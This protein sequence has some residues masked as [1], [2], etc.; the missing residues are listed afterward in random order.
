MSSHPLTLVITSHRFI[1]TRGRFFTSGYF[2]YQMTIYRQGRP[3]ITKEVR[4]KDFVSFRTEL[5]RLNESLPKLPKTGSRHLT[6]LGEAVKREQLLNLFLQRLVQIP[7]I[8]SSPLFRNFCT[9]CPK[10]EVLSRWTQPRLPTRSTP[11]RATF[12]STSKQVSADISRRESNTLIDLLNQSGATIQPSS[13]SSADIISPFGV[14]HQNFYCSICDKKCTSEFN[15]SQHLAGKRHSRTISSPFIN[16]C[17]ITETHD[18]N[19]YVHTP[20]SCYLSL[21]HPNSQALSYSIKLQ[22]HFPPSS[23]FLRREF[24]RNHQILLEELGSFLIKTFF[25]SRCQI[26]LT[27]P[28]SSP[29]STE[30]F[31]YSAKLILLFYPLRESFENFFCS[32]LSSYIWIEV[33]ECQPLNSFQNR[34]SFLNNADLCITA[35]W[36]ADTLVTIGFSPER[37]QII[38]ISAQKQLTNSSPTI[39]LEVKHIQDDNFFTSATASL[40]L[41]HRERRKNFLWLETSCNFSTFALILTLRDM[42]GISIITPGIS[43]QPTTHSV[44]LLKFSKHAYTL[45]PRFITGPHSP[46]SELIFQRPTSTSYI[47]FHI[48]ELF[49]PSIDSFRFDLVFNH[50]F[51]YIA[52]CFDLHDYLQFSPSSEDTSLTN[53]YDIGQ[54]YQ[55][56]R[57]NLG[58]FGLDDETTKSRLMIIF[59]HSNIDLQIL[60]GLQ[61][62]ICDFFSEL[63]FNIPSDSILYA[64]QLS[65]DLNADEFLL[66]RFQF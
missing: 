41:Q 66:N 46:K 22:L 34:F 61:N 63:T 56:I 51:S 23:P 26:S 11:R 43:D 17:K 1:Q 59:S 29:S 58:V 18:E 64:Y 30:Q 10:D 52:L 50:C 16:T 25:R 14:D 4:Y 49:F 7:D 20:P 21:L 13:S 47:S 39:R 9:A 57:R 32:M 15:F 37:S 2:L 8:E 62:E 54:L 3:T 5:G 36:I 44:Y 27:Q 35:R 38:H 28:A 55:N 53:L 42:I 24:V 45:V 12:L 19:I 48:T 65:L 60:Y 6:D 40:P 33:L 31:I